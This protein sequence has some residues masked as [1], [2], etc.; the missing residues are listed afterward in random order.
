MFPTL[1]DSTV[2][3]AILSLDR[4]TITPPAIPSATQSFASP[5]RV[6]VILLTINAPNACTCNQCQSDCLFWESNIPI[7]WYNLTSSSAIPS[8]R[9]SF[10]HSLIAQWKSRESRWSNELLRRAIRSR[11]ALLPSDTFS[12]TSNSR[13]R[14]MYYF[15]CILDSLAT[16]QSFQSHNQADDMRECLSQ[17]PSE[18]KVAR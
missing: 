10:A 6:I 4:M 13:A 5:I 11:A 1:A 14:S 12:G 18:R 2:F 15:R 9:T 17:E 8:L 16:I 3:A 7:F